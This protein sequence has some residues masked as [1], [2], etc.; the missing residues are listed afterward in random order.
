MIAAV[1]VTLSRPAYNTTVASRT[2]KRINELKAV[3]VQKGVLLKPEVYGTAAE[4]VWFA[5]NA[6]LDSEKELSGAYDKL[7]KMMTVTFT[8]GVFRW[9]LNHTTFLTRTALMVKRGH[10]DRVVE[11]VVELV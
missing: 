9:I 5:L 10:K 8:E 7:V 1:I 3:L 6:Y 2:D 11:S 4:H